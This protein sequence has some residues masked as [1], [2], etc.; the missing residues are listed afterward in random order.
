MH[1]HRALL[2]EHSEAG[3]DRGV[4]REDLEEHLRDV[5]PAIGLDG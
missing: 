1:V 5:R 3:R 4:P 2:R